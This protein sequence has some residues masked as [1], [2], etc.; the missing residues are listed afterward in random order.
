MTSFDDVNRLILAA[1][2]VPEGGSLGPALKEI[3][4]GDFQRGYIT[5]GHSADSPANRKI[6]QPVPPEGG[7]RS[8]SL[9]TTPDPDDEGPADG[10]EVEKVVTP[11]DFAR[12]PLIQGHAL[13]SPGD[14]AD[15]NSVAPVTGSG[16]ETYRHAAE[17]YNANVA[18]ERAQHVSPSRACEARPAPA[19]WSPPPDM[20]ARNVPQPR[21]AGATRKAPGE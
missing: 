8:S 18:R 6:A 11:E 1:A 4:P 2:G 12:G 13:P 14:L 20:G 16:T 7:G 17:A 21:A 19:R 3:S 5:A 15:N 10:G 9:C